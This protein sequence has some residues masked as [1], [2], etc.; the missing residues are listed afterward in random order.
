MTVLDNKMPS[1]ATAWVNPN[2]VTLKASTENSAKNLLQFQQNRNSIGGGTGEF[3]VS[4][5]A[6]KIASHFST[7]EKRKEIARTRSGF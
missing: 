1:K 3:V 7:T 6:K 4:S 5:S 2:V